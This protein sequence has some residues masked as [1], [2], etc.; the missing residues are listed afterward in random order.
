M[1]RQEREYDYSND[2][3]DEP[4]GFAA[5]NRATHGGEFSKTGGTPRDV[6]NSRIAHGDSLG[7]DGSQNRDS[8]ATLSV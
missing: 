4:Q 3:A 8:W 7:G 1:I 6:P 2:G 5:K